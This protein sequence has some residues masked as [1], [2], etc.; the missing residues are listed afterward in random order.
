MKL[1]VNKCKGRNTVYLPKEEF[2]NYEYVFVYKEQ[3]FS[4]SER[5]ITMMIKINELDKT[6]KEMKK[7]KTNITN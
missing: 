1:K 2:S 4:D 3:Q 7:W 5:Q 6:L